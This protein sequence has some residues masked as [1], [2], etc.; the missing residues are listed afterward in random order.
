MLLDRTA[1]RLI[2][3]EREVP[4]RIVVVV[5]VR[6]VLVVPAVGA[7]EE[8]STR[9]EERVERVEHTREIRIGNVE[10]A[11]HR[12]D[13]VEGLRWEIEMEEVHLVRLDTFLAA[14]P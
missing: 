7:D 14:V 2:R 6:T 5:R 11:E 1:H 9:N 12:V 8:Q 4:R 10:H 3:S 13:G